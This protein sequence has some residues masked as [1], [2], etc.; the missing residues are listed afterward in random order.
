MVVGGYGHGL[1]KGPAEGS[2]SRWFPTWSQM[3]LAEDLDGRFPGELSEAL[4]ELP[5][6]NA[7]R[8]NLS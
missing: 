5:D 4:Y 1:H 7:D 3:G 8:P 6:I 2:I